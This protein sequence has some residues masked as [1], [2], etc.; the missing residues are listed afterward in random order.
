GPLADALAGLDDKLHAL[1]GSE[2]RRGRRSGGQGEPTLT[3]L[4]GELDRLLD[5]LQGAD[6]APTTQA[7][8]ASAEA[9]KVLR[10]LLDRWRDLTE[11]DVKAIN[12]RVDKGGLPPPS[13]REATG[14]P[15]HGCTNA[16]E[17]K[18]RSG[19]GIPVPPGGGQPCLSVCAPSSPFLLPFS[20]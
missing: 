14:V 11:G 17:A 3:R 16:R 6:V 9:Q 12:E 5:V 1:E 10:D 18:P 13:P 2:R 15:P 20:G 7:V 8:T 4:A 19:A